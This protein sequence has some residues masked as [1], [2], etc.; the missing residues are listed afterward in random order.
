MNKIAKIA[1]LAALVLVALPPLLYFGGVMGLEAVKW[2]AVAGTLGWFGATPM[3]MSREL[4]AD[5][6]EVEI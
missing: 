4:P 6:R 5:A 2:A 3:W 1:S